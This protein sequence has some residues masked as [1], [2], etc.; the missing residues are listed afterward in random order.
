MYLRAIKRPYYYY[1]YYYIVIFNM[2]IDKGDRG[3]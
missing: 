1:Y 3:A 2:P